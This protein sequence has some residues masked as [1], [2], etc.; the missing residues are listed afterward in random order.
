MTDNL[1]E[2]LGALEQSARRAAEALTKLR[3]ERDALAA[4]LAALEGQRAELER[5]RQERKDVLAQVD[6]ILKEL[7]RLT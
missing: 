5:L 1:S 3:I 6:S 4:K 7:D 2:R